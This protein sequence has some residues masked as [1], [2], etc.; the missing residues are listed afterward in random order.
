MEKII[1][2]EMNFGDYERIKDVLQIEFDEFWSPEILKKELENPNS[3]YI[4]AFGNNEIVGFAGITYNFDY[5]EIMNIA[6]R[7]DMRRRGIATKLMEKLI[8]LANEF[9]VSKVA[10][11]VDSKN[12]S[13]RNLYKK[14][15]FKEVGIRK[16]YYYGNSD[17]ILM[18]FYL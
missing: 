2:D 1:I 7:K 15:G 9:N 13:A 11:E 6:I 14:I 18:D 3:K 16:N 4:V 12:I 8:L 5:I 17:A 10:L